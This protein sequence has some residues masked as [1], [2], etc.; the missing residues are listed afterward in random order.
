M[1]METITFCL[2]LFTT[3]RTFQVVLSEFILRQGRDSRFEILHS[4]RHNYFCTAV[5]SYTT[6]RIID[7]IITNRL[8]LLVKENLIS[9]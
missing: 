6:N 4:I 9:F 2:Q 7:I 1:T 5:V 3:L 8:K